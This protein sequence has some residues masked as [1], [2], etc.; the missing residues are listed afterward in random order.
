[1]RRRTFLKNQTAKLFKWIV[2]PASVL[3]AFFA[4]EVSLVSSS[5]QAG[6]I[7]QYYTGVRTLGMGGSYTATVN[8][9]TAVLTNPAGLGK[10]RDVTWTLADPEV[11]GSYTDTELA[12]GANSSKVFDVQGLLDVLNQNKGTHWNAKGQV[13]PSLVAPNFGIGLHAKYSYDGEVNTAGTLYQFDYT[14]DY[15]AAMGYCFRFF[16]GIIKL[17]TSVRAVDRV[18]AHKSL[19]ATST[20][21]K[22]TALASEGLG[23][24]TDVG[25]ILTAPIALLPSLAVVVRDAGNTSYGLSSG[26]IMATTS[27]PADSIQKIDAGLSVSPIISNHNRMT[28][29]GEMH[30]VMNVNKE[31]DPIRRVHAGLEFNIHDFL[32]IRGGMNQRYWTAG[33]ELSSVRFQLQAA[34][35]GEDVGPDLAPKEDRRFVGKFAIRF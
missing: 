20:N 22:L 3:F 30:D 6:E 21:L 28:L 33:L 14:G 19:P 29:T 7:Y 1:M 4:F 24:A 31:Q 10:I 35:Y 25:L 18:E 16:G 34:T 9:E 27:R 8:D 17:G 2:I 11:A 23:V 26:M 5:A 12:T 13:F 32:F 15:A